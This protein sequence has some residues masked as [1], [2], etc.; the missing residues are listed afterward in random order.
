VFDA[1]TISLEGASKNL[2]LCLQRAVAAPAKD[3]ACSL[4][5]IG[6]DKDASPSIH[7][8]LIATLLQ[9]L[10]RRIILAVFTRLR[11]VS[12]DRRPTMLVL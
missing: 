2:S 1:N 7:F 11:L 3:L 9:S 4:T 5:E 8:F 12:D 6:L 10:L